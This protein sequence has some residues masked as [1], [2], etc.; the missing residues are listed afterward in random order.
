MMFWNKLKEIGRVV[1]EIP[2]DEIE[3]PEGRIRKVKYDESL[4]SLAASIREHGVIEPIIVRRCDEN[5]YP[6]TLIA[7]ERRLR[8]AEAASLDTVP[9]VCVEADDIDAAVIAVTENLHREDLTIFEEAASI[10]SLITLT[11]M[12]Q[13]VCARKLGVSQ[14]YVANKMRLL[15]LS[16]A[17][18][19][20]IISNSLSERHARALLR[21]DAGEEREDALECVIREEMN[22]A[23]A[24]EYLEA[25]ICAKSRIRERE[26]RADKTGA[27]QKQKLVIRDIRLFYNSIDHAVDIIKKSGIAV[28]SSRREIDSGV[29]IEILLPK[30]AG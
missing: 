21:L 1:R 8:A 30:K 3:V 16:A 18:Q 4:R 13:E 27:E 26:E 2:L 23:R 12:T 22:V 24:E 20:K 25:L 11:G 15:K 17:E 7:G 5:G 28:E 14:S 9:A 6:Y 10:K 29:L 19:E